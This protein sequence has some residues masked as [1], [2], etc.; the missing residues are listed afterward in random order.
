[1][2][3]N[4]Y[5]SLWEA[6]PPLCPSPEEFEKH[7]VCLQWKHHPGYTF[8]SRW[9]PSVPVRMLIVGKKWNIEMWFYLVLWGEL[10]LKDLPSDFHQAVKTTGWRP[11]SNNQLVV[12]ILTDLNILISSTGL[13]TGPCVKRQLHLLRLCYFS[14]PM[15]YVVGFISVLICHVVHAI[16]NY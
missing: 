2:C 10:A 7:E 12:V 4:G 13:I 8:S 16:T 6:Q 15:F 14:W 9:C 11:L 5:R 3:L 1:M